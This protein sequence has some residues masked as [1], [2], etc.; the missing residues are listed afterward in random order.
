VVQT[1]LE[2]TGPLFKKI[3]GIVCGKGNNGGDGWVAAR[4][5]KKMGVDVRVVLADDPKTFGKETAAQYQKAKSLQVPVLRAMKRE[6]LPAVREDLGKCDFLVDA[7]LG[8]GLSRAPEGMVRELILLMNRSEKP[9]LAVDTP[10]GLS[11]DTGLAWGEAVRAKWTVTFGLSKVGFYM[12]KAAAYT[13]EVGVADLGLPAELLCSDFLKIEMTDL[14][15]VRKSLPLY[16]DN[17]NKGSRGRVLVVAGSLGFTGA[18]ALSAWGAQR[19]GAGLVTVACAKS[20]NPI[21]ASKL[22]ECMTAPV[23]EAAGGFLSFKAAKA[24]L[25]LAAKAKA[26]VIGPGLGRHAQTGRLL[27]QILPRLTTPMVL[28]ADALFFLGEQFKHSGSFRGFK[29]PAILTPH[30]GEAARLLKTSIQDVEQNRL[31]VAKQI[32]AEYNAVA[33][34]KGRHTV[35]ANPQGDVR[36]NSTGNRGLATGGTGDVLSGILGGLLA[37]GLSVFDAAATGVYLHGLA[38][39]KASRRFGPDGLL[40]GDLLPILPRLLR[41]VRK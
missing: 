17:I 41:Q 39:E 33:I 9:I 24:V 32:A 23:A 3:I 38:G 40:A 25:S 35:I 13:G 6:D 8:T 7:L 2:K 27:K 4:L 15:F 11:V 37:Q 20:L 10:S 16:D 22:T 29:T 21:L 14:A 36:V 28:D 26:L 34:L 31:K 1:L 12:P 30:P 18:A 5:L 19:I